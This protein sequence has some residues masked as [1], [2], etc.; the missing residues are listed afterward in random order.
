ML[1]DSEKP[2]ADNYIER[3]GDARV[4]PIAF[5]EYQE[6][7]EFVYNDQL[8]EIYQ[9]QISEAEGNDDKIQKIQEQIKKSSE[10]KE[11]AFKRMSTRLSGN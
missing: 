2:E 9:N 5:K 6:W 1:N 11:S 7:G 10:I 4:I 8:L 3:H